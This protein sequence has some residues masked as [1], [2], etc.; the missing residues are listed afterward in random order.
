MAGPGKI[1][2]SN[3]KWYGAIVIGSKHRVNLPSGAFLDFSGPALIMAIVNCND[4]SF[5]A[6]SRALG[7]KAVEKALA[8]EREGASIIDFGA[9]SSRPG[10]LYISLEEELERLVP[11]LTAFRKR[12]SL[13]VS[14]DT[15]KAA[16]ARSALDAG[17]DIIN[18]IS[19]LT[20]DPDM[21]QVCVSSGAAVVLMHKKGVPLSM[22]E[23]P[24][25][26]DVACEL[27]NF[28]LKAAGRAR[29]AG[30][31]G[32]KIILDPGIGFGKTRENNLEILCRLAEICGTDYP[33]MAG[34]SHKQFI[35]EITGRNEGEGLSGTLAA[36]G[37][38]IMNGASII[39]VHDVREHVDLVKVLY[40][41][42]GAV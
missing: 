16:V 10:S 19:A 41:L 37:A 30:I 32:E 22:Q 12:S 24:R 9:E 15:R 26:D 36:N 13:P 27:K 2:F 31:P 6:D 8:A 42:Q 39:R 23:D 1:F 17:A 14:V 38:A 25:Y 7:E 35:G 40:A 34:V 21:A 11:V 3:E 33:V 28:F 29:A 20:D 5:Y 18:D 4:D